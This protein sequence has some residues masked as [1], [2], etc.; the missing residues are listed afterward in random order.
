MAKNIPQL[1]RLLKDKENDRAVLKQYLVNMM[2]DGQRI[3]LY[4]VYRSLS[5]FPAAA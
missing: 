3:R 5:E 2:G 4:C 1:F